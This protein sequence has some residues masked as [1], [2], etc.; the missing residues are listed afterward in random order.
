M[1]DMAT[2]KPHNALSAKRREEI[3]RAM[4]QSF[5]DLRCAYKAE[6]D[7]VVD[8][9]HFIDQGSESSKAVKKAIATGDYELACLACCLNEALISMMY[10]HEAS[11]VFL[12]LWMETMPKDMREYLVAN[13]TK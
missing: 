13:T 2:K 7:G 6:M 9:D 3:R 11:E 10:L 12:P 1:V 4:A 5:V 8:W